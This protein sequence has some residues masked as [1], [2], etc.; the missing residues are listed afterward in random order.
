MPSWLVQ[1]WGIAIFGLLVA[2]VYRASHS[3]GMMT[4]QRQPIRDHLQFLYGDKTGQ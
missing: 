2:I 1:W 3:V 4:D